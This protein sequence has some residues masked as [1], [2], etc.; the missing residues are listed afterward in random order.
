LLDTG[1]TYNPH[2]K[3]FVNCNHDINDRTREH[4]VLW[5]AVNEYYSTVRSASTVLCGLT[6]KSS[7][8]EAQHQ[9]EEV[10]FSIAITGGTQPTHTRRWNNKDART[11]ASPQ[12]SAQQS[13]A[14]PSQPDFSM[15]YQT[16]AA[17]PIP[18]TDG[19]PESRRPG[20]SQPQC[21]TET[22][23]KQQEELMRNF[24]QWMSHNAQRQAIP[25]TPPGPSFDSWAMPPLGLA[26][27]QFST[28][29]FDSP[30]RNTPPPPEHPPHQ[31]TPPPPSSAVPVRQPASPPEV[32][33]VYFPV[34]PD[35]Q[36]DYAISGNYS[37]TCNG[38]AALWVKTAKY[39]KL[40]ISC[41]IWYET[42]LQQQRDWAA[43]TTPPPN[44]SAS[45]AILDAI[46]NITYETSPTMP[47]S[48]TGNATNPDPWTEVD[49]WSRGAATTTTQPQEFPPTRSSTRTAQDQ[50]ARDLLAPYLL[51]GDNAKQRGQNRFAARRKAFNVG[52]PL[53]PLLGPLGAYPA[54]PPYATE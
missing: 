33:G 21:H 7:F 17:S 5:K 51:A 13:Q 14:S 25:V 23:L 26:N 32:R 43:F 16:W 54:H 9:F 29:A 8:I 34:E 18:G 37:A 46:S 2:I 6:R 10:C 44:P 31:H 45:L 20:F 11:G 53:P 3:A 24:A 22:A 15:D 50:A 38:V 12:S 30:R 49:P 41:T 36:C 48:A 35:N 42:H 1:S 4:T 28:G 27:A 39:K 52:M 40:C 19:P 47:Q